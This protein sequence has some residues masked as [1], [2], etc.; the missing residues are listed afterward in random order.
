MNVYSTKIKS[1]SLVEQMT[2]TERMICTVMTFTKISGKN[3]K[4]QGT[5]LYQDQE[6]NVLSTK[7]AF[8]FLVVIRKNKV[9]SIKICLALT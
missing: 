3:F 5:L 1:I 8:T 6:L 4:Q 7:N 9:I 2:M